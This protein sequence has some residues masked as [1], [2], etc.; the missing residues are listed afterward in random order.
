M[1][2]FLEPLLVFWNKARTYR[3]FYTFGFIAVTTALIWL[4]ET[5]PAPS[6]LAC[7]FAVEILIFQFNVLAGREEAPIRIRVFKNM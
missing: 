4:L 2:D 6:G 7:L 1:A 3:G 5:L